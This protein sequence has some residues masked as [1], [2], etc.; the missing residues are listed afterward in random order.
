MRWLSRVALLVA[1]LA[2]A[3]FFLTPSALVNSAA[4]TTLPD[5]LDRY[6]ADRERRVDERHGLVPDTQKR[7][8]W[9]AKPARTDYVVVYLHGFS[10]TRQESAPLAER[11]A[12]SLGANLFETRLSGHGQLSDPLT[13]FKAEDW[14]AD[15]AE[16]L[17]IAARLGDEIIL[18][19]TSTGATLAVAM[20]THTA[21]ESVSTLVLISPNF[22]PAN[23][24]A[25][26][27]TAPAGPLI[28][29]LLAG[30]THSFEP[31]NEQQA[32]FWTTSYPI[33]AAVEMM[34]LVDYAQS[35]LPLELEA[36]LLV[37]YSRAD[38]VVSPAATLAATA[39]ITAT[40]QQLIEVTRSGDPSHH[41]LAGDILSP[42][43]TDEIVAEIVGFV[44]NPD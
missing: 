34:R 1:L 24:D 12:D 3:G 8:R 21:F 7:I 2:V 30:D 5:D 26:L 38:E 40:R 9:Q 28:A 25:R 14:I 33:D 42:A 19:G 10:A 31:I 18:I 32:R 23:A 13:A 44:R 35:I 20:A 15:A 16:A 17:A 6:L 4:V 27:L 39:R 43:T 37:I 41:V 36:D 29:R 22:A 11:V